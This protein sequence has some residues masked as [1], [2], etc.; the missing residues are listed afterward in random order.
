M[1]HF[2]LQ[3]FFDILDG[4]LISYENSQALSASSTMPGKLTFIFVAMI[5][6][7]SACCHHDFDVCYNGM[8]IHYLNLC[9]AQANVLWCIE[10]CHIDFGKQKSTLFSC[11][12][13][14]NNVYTER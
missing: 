2:I 12:S 8:V 5:F 13:S 14:F 6:E 9:F 11:L 3:S 1:K 7:M 4:K 10:G